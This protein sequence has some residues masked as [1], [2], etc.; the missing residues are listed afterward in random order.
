VRRIPWGGRK[1]YAGLVAELIETAEA[2]FRF[3]MPSKDGPSL[4]ARLQ[5][6]ETNFGIRDPSLDSVPK[7][8]EA[9]A[10]LLGWFHEL[11]GGRQ[12]YGFGPAAFTFAEICAWS[13]LKG[14]RP[15]PWEVD[16][17]K[18]LDRIWL[19]TWGDFNTSD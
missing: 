8:P 9:V 14:I 16:C 11:S 4:R 7:P 19:K 15:A 6:R 17:I 13:D 12:S 3:D 5:A 18:T 10:Y 1:F 2:N